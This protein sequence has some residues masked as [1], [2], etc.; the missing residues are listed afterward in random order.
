[1][2]ERTGADGAGHLV[3]SIEAENV[4]RLTGVGKSLVKL[5]GQQG[6]VV[7]G[8][9]REFARILGVGYQAFH[10]GPDGSPGRRLSAADFQAMESENIVLLPD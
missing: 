9:R 2:P 7:I 6:R 4:G 10:L 1:M 3:G 8:A 5:V